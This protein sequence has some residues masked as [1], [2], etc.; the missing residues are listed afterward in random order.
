MRY[1]SHHRPMPESEIPATDEKP[2]PGR[3]IRVREGD[4][5]YATW[6]EWDHPLGGVGRWAVVIRPLRSGV[7]A[8][9]LVDGYPLAPRGVRAFQAIEDHREVQHGRYE[10]A[11]K[12]HEIARESGLYTAEQL[13]E[14]P[15]YPAW[16]SRPLPR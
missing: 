6:P 13:G 12:A 10:R 3:L 8:A 16:L 1:V 7:E 9:P 5:A 15:T 4:P 11:V 2:G 14:P